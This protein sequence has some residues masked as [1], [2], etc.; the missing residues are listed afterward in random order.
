MIYVI[1]CGGHYARWE[2]PRQ[3]LPVFDE[4][5]VARTI[6]LLKNEGVTDIR[7]SAQ[8]KRFERF[9]VPVIHHVNSMKVS[10]GE[11]TEGAWVD[12]FCP[13]DEPACYI[14]GDVVFSQQAISTI[15]RQETESIH[16]FASAPPFS[17]HYFKPWAEPFAFKVQDQKRFRAAIDFVRAN[18]K[19]GIF[20]R[21]PIAW[22]LWQVIRGR[23]VRQIDYDSYCAINDWTTDI[24]KPEDIKRLE[25]VLC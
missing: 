17:K 6:R 19:T 5:I 22:E 15:V 16:F 24:D 7:I 12:A 2:K 10:G 11:V 3:L 23:D 9:G 18:V 21:H 14:M 25:A 4:P 1:M 20:W 13:M 8:D